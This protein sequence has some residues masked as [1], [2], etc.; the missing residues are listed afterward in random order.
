MIRLQGVSKVYDGSTVAIRDAN[1]T[2]QKGEFVFLSGPRAR[3]S[4]R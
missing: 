4:R 2:I 3:A 1:T